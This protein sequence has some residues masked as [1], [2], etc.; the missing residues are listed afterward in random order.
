VNSTDTFSWGIPGPSADIA[1]T[2]P[3]DSGKATIFGYEAG[4]AMIGVSAPERRVGLWLGPVSAQ[5]LTQPPLYGSVLLDAAI[6]W[7]LGSDG[8]RDGLGYLEE[9]L[10]G[11]NPADPDSNDDGILDGAAADSSISGTNLDSDGDGLTNAQELAKGTDPF[12]WDTDGDG[13][14]DAADCFPL[15]PAYICLPDTPGPPFITLTEPTN[16]Q[17]QTSVCVPAI[18]CPQ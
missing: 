10:F 3:S 15:D 4:D 12:R 7:A 1:A 9:F 14:S 17:L 2:L 18:P 8:D 13:S 6:A 11:T 5:S 16:A